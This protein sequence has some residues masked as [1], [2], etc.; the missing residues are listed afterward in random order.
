MEIKE[1]ISTSASKERLALV[2]MGESVSW[3]PHK[4]IYRKT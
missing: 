1:T 3:R 2:S 4:P